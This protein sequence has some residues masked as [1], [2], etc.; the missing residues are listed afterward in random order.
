MTNTE[1]KLAT[2]RKVDAVDP[3]ENADSIE[4]ATIG[5]WKVVVKRGDFTPGDL[6]LYIE[7]DS[8]IPTEL[9]PFLSKDKE[10]RVY[11]GVRGERLRTVRLRQQISQG[12]LLPVYQDDTGFYIR[13][14]TGTPIEVEEDQDVTEVLGIQKWERPMSA[15]LAGICRGSFPRWFPKTNQDRVQNLSRELEFWKDQ[16]LSWEITEKMEGCVFEGTLINTPNGMI[17]A[18]DI[19]PGDEVYS[20]SIDTNEIKV[21]VVSGVLHRTEVEEWYD[22]EL[23]DGTLLRVTGNHPIYLTDEKC[24]RRTDQLNIGDSVLKYEK[25]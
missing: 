20:Y 22:I 13:D 7:I 1:R 25:I 9:A 6:G 24:Y 16:K 23:E 5:G 3:I 19:K 2:I 4:V 21:D 8:W 10:P 14:C 18:E 15:Q 12:L 11:N 17:L